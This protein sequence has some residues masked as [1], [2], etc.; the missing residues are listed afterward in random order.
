MSK[1]SGEPTRDFLQHKK[2]EDK[3]FKHL[4]ASIVITVS[5]SQIEKKSIMKI[6]C[7]LAREY[8]VKVCHDESMSSNT[9]R[10]QQANRGL[11]G[12]LRIR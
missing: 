1:C 11:F 2:A 8:Y 3:I 6:F 4:I 12:K 5:T 7:G 10:S 9:I